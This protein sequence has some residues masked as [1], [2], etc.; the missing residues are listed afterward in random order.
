MFKENSSLGGWMADRNACWPM[1]ENL[2]C[3]MMDNADLW[4][5]GYKDN[6]FFATICKHMNHTGI[7]SHMIIFRS[8]GAATMGQTRS[9]LVS[10]LQEDVPP[11]PWKEE[12]EA[13]ALSWSLVW[14]IIVCKRQKQWK[15]SGGLLAHVVSLPPYSAIPPKLTMIAS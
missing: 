4:Y 13:P 9:S 2:L 14:Y 5:A 6:L 8:S 1:G 7:S 11:L 15:K 3:S 10:C 12:E